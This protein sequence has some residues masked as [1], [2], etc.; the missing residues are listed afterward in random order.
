[1]SI[2][3]H[4]SLIFICHIVSVCFGSVHE[5]AT[6]H[7][8]G[9][10]G[11][12]DCYSANTLG[13][14]RLVLKVSGDFAYDPNMVSYYRVP[15]NTDT[16]QRF[17]VL[18]GF[19]PSVAFGIT[20]FLDAS[21]MQPFYFDILAGL[22]PSGGVGDL[23][24]SLKC[25]IPGGKPRVI[26]GAIL[27]N[28]TFPTGNRAKGYFVR[29]AYYLNKDPV[30]GL[31]EYHDEPTAFFTATKP[32]L[33]LLSAG[34]VNCKMFMFHAN[35][36]T[37]LTFDR[38][39]DNALI[40]SAGMELHPAEWFGFFTDIYAEPR[41]GRLKDGLT[42]DKD[43][44]HFSSGLTLSTPGGG[45]LTVGGTFKL[46]SNR[47]RVYWDRTR[48]KE[49]HSRTEP[50][51]RLFVQLG[52]NGFIVTRDR[53]GD[54]L[55]DRDDMCPDVPEDVDGF[56]DS[57]GCPDPDNDKDKIMD[58]DDSCKNEPEDVD[59][60]KDD[61]GCPDMD[62]DLDAIPDTVDN[63]ISEAEDRDGFEDEDGCPD[64][65]NDNDGVPD[66]LDKC[67]GSPEDRDHF[68]DEDGCPDRDND[69]DAVPDSVDRCP[70]TAGLPEKDGCPEP[71]EKAKEIRRG[72]LI[73]S[74]VKF[75]GK[76]ADLTLGSMG[77]LDRVYQ[78]LVDWPEVHLDI[79]AHTD[80]SVPPDESMMISKQ[81]AEVVR[82]YLLNKGIDPVRLTATGKGSTAPIADNSSVQG[83]ELNNRIEIHR[84]D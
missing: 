27:S 2:K 36:G 58:T 69:L 64:N 82:D 43:L 33:S 67:I 28:L 18:Y 61:D 9:Q 72:R 63:C 31:F 32:T 68:E 73:L 39:L 74:Q 45:L 84:T 21:L 78:S 70:D 37:C 62:N 40:G 8:G 38:R 10:L 59:G 5:F 49:I 71:K 50:L 3:R 15:G 75:D 81:R 66:S 51:W 19:Y 17:S 80:N 48:E 55:R 76:S 42:I 20:D 11:L 46:S 23:H 6:L 30:P 7:P 14:T 4:F 65:D 24:F 22:L 34:S 26:D 35:F 25:R 54:G 47:P 60:F 16:T 52:W 56:K 77:D 12:T 44:F 29:H 53:D 57:D 13:F 41:I 79:Q 83:R 1:M